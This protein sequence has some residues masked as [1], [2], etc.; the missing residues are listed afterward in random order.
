MKK[1]VSIIF[2]LMLFGFGFVKFHSSV[3][4]LET[5]TQ[6]DC[7]TLHLCQT[8]FEKYR[9]VIDLSLKTNTNILLL[10]A[11]DF[12]QMAEGYGAFDTQGQYFLLISIRLKKRVVE[13][14]GG[15][16]SNEVYETYNSIF[17]DLSEKLEACN[18]KLP[19]I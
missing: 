17:I 18:M 13:M 14:E 15:T 7:Q 10:A 11:R 19:E 9:E 4:A 12:G 8:V 2:L 3:S 5:E 16:L 1:T 6:D